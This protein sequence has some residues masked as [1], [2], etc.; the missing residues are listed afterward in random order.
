[1]YFCVS[2][3]FSIM[4]RFNFLIIFLLSNL[5]ATSQV[6]IKISI[7]NILSDSISYGQF[8]G[9]RFVEIGKI[10][11]TTGNIYHLTDNSLQSGIYVIQFGR[12]NNALDQKK[13]QFIIE[14]ANKSFEM[15]IDGYLTNTA[16]FVNSETNTQLH[17]YINKLESIVVSNRTL[18]QN[19]LIEEDEASFTAFMN[20][21]QELKKIN[22]SYSLNAKSIIFKDYLKSSFINFPIY[23]GTLS[24]KKKQRQDFVDN[25][26]LEGLDLKSNT[27][28]QVEKSVDLLDYYTIYAADADHNKVS[29]RCIKIINNLLK[30]NEIAGQYYLN[31]LLNSMPRITTY[32]YDLV[33]I[34]LE[35]EFLS[36]NKFVGIS[37]EKIERIK[38]TNKKILKMSE[39]QILADIEFNTADD[40][41]QKVYD[42]GGKY[43]L[44]V[45]WS[46]D[47]GHCKKELPALNR[48]FNKYKNKQIKV[49]AICT[50]RDAV[51]LKMCSDFLASSAISTEWLSL[52]D[53]EGKSGYAVAY[54]VSAFPML[55][56][57]D[58]DKKIKYKR[59]G[60]MTEAELDKLFRLLD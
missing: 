1:M 35:K 23:S 47:C 20:N 8:L 21:E 6:D 57:I 34:A 51:G 2:K 42:I 29:E 11:R 3:W 53:K 60:E 39:G 49:G 55:I 26:F 38:E 5:I 30:T 46:P 41:K 48:V 14:E 4:N 45:F 10:K 33:S 37:N 25:K 22:Q 54:D 36:S 17:Q 27:F 13:S 18:R 7:R 59:R 16:T 32:Q 40:K 50:K 9:K 43:T 12:E 15:N 24:E 58:K 56:L 44:L 19:W 31:Y 28:W 52:N